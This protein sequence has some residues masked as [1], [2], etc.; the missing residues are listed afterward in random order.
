MSSVTIPIPSGKVLHWK[1]VGGEKVEIELMR[2]LTPSEA[3]ARTDAPYNRK[4]AA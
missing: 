2:F 3:K 1:R 4:D